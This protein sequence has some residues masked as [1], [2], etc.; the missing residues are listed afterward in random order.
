MLNIN[1]SKTE[2]LSEE[3]KETVNKA[4]DNVKSSANKANQSIAKAANNTEDHAESL[5]NGLRDLINQHS[6]PS[7]I[8]AMKNRF[9]E[10]AT[11]LKSVVGHEITNAYDVSK[12]RAVEQ[13]K[14]HPLGT[15]AL[16]AGAGLLLGFILGTKQSSK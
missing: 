2:E 12:E 16:V 4:S 11:E 7:D 8:N 1:K 14:N 15:V 13:V 5:I 6:S 10:K 9:V 3:A